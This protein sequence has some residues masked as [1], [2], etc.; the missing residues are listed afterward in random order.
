MIRL[1]ALRANEKISQQKIA[2]YLNVSRSTVAMWETG[3]IEP[4]FEIL[5]KLATY[6][7]VTTDYLLGINSDN[8]TESSLSKHPK[9]HG[10]KIP[11]YG[12]V[13]A[14]VPIL[15]IE[16][17]DS[18]DPDDWEEI[19]EKM[20]ANGEYIALRIKGD[21]M[22]P[23]ISTGDVV[24]VR[25]QPDAETGDIVVAMVNGDEATVK[26]LKKRPEGILLIPSNPKYEPMFYTNEDIENLPIRIL[27]RVVELRAKF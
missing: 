15:A 11:V 9:K 7:G 10:I 4:S 20:A 1:K 8:F 23:K 13:A 19:D 17:Y 2:D 18:A 12:N 14:G 24:I 21:S 3:G 25:L 5:E 22:E 16:N 27:G 6:F 26:K